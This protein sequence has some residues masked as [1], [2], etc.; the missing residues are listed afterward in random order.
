MKATE[1]KERIFI[2]L[3]EPAYI[4][5]GITQTYFNS[6]TID[7]KLQFMPEKQPYSYKENIETEGK[8]VQQENFFYYK[9][10]KWQK[11]H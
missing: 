3:P 1:T 8:I 5:Q 4:A 7:K 9:D 2:P 6:R 11:I 10:G